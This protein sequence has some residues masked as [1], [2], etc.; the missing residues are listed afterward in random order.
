MRAAMSG[1]ER[2]LVES[3]ERLRERIAWLLVNPLH[4]QHL[5][6]SVDLV[7]LYL[8]D[9]ARCGLHFP[10]DEGRFDRQLTMPAIDQGEK[11]NAAWPAVV[12]E[13]I[14]RG[15]DSAAGV[16]HIVNQHNIAGIHI[17]AD[18]AV[19]HHRAYVARG[20]IVA[21]EVDI[22]NTAINRMFLDVCNHL[23]KAVRQGN[24]AAL[25]SD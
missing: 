13:C 19:L 8:Y 1:T 11:L 12:E 23:C 4:Q 2:S 3:S 25:D 21:V 14:E 6:V 5:L 24:A 18:G 15:A 17:E 20:K 16:K 9:L 22:Q 10:T 7:K